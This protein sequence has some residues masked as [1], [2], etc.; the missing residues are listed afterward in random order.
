MGQIQEQGAGDETGL[1]TQFVNIFS[2]DSVAPVLMVS[3]RCR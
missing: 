1:L 2:G 3:R